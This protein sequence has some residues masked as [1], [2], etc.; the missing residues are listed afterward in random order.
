MLTIHD[1][2]LVR[3][4]YA[5]VSP[6]RDAVAD[7]F[8]DR[9]FVIAPELRA[10]FPENL[11]EQK[12]KLMTMIGTAVGGLDDVAKLV[13]T[14]RALGARHAGYGVTMGHYALVGE[15][16]LWTLQQGLG[17]KFTTD[18]KSAWI[19]VYGILAMTMEAGAAEVAAPQAA[20]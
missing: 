14:V 7:L 18:V 11:A 12:R 1:V 20:E 8:Y 15:A 10:L 3:A 19:K 16:L 2:A 17:D 5:L 9:L 13:P 4:S 6:I